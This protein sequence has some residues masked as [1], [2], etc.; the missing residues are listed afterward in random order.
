MLNLALASNEPRAK[1]LFAKLREYGNVICEMDFDRIDAFTK[2]L[3]AAL[4]F[5]RPREEWWGNYQMHPLIQRRRRRV[6]QA[7][8]K[9]HREPLDALLMW[10]SWFHPFKR[11]REAGVPFFHYIDQSRSLRPL[12][13]EPETS[14]WGRRK[15]FS[16]QAETYADCSGIFCMSQWA[17]AQ[18]LAAHNVCEEK[19]HVVGWGPCAIDLSG[20]EI[21]PDARK[22]LVLHVS[23]DFHRKG[24]DYLLQTAICIADLAPHIEFIVIGKDETF[25][26]RKIPKNVKFIGPI[27]DGVL[28]SRYFQEASVFFLPHRFDRSPHVL[29]EA[30]SAGLPIVTSDQGGPVELIKGQ[31][32]GYLVPIGDVRGYAEAIIKLVTDQSTRDVMGHAARTLMR[33]KYTWSVVAQRIAGL[34]TEALARR[35]PARTAPEGGRHPDLPQCNCAA[36]RKTYTP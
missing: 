15:S 3:A 12:L 13:G 24:V 25:T 5:K 29:V 17:R 34:I 32:T 14:E 7:E 2:Y 16:L 19:V 28:L 23:N 30:M 9:P 11:S 22:P 21:N 35:P 26:P 18:T 31:N 4:S 33:E 10:G 20:Q 27:Y 6:L 36:L 8:I 1:P